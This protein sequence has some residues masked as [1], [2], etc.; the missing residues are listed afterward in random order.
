[1]MGKIWESSIMAVE[2]PLNFSGLPRVTA[3]L[4]G[5][6]LRPLGHISAD[7]S[8]CAGPEKQ[9]KKVHVGTI[10]LCRKR[11]KSPD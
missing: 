3:P 1:M 10:L 5:E 11:L 7:P 6:R 8:N 9:A 2:K 4:A